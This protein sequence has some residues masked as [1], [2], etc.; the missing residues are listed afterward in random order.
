LL[1]K[2]GAPAPK[3]RAFKAKEISADWYLQ[4]RGKLRAGEIKSEKTFRDVSERY[5]HEY[6][7]I[8]QGQRS[9]ASVWIA[10]RKGARTPVLASP[11][12]R[13]VR[14]SGPSLTGGIE[15]H[16][17]EGVRSASIQPRRPSPTVSNLETKSDSM[18]Q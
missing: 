2:I 6:D 12:L 4:L 9:P 15:N 3:K 1:A 8:T 7:I 11:S 16:T 14:L 5:L 18:S 10:L 13:I 17:I